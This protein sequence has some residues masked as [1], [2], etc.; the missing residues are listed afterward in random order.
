MQYEIKYIK[1]ETRIIDGKLVT[2]EKE[3]DPPKANTI[4]Q[5]GPMR[6]DRLTSNMQAE[7]KPIKT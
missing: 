2:I 3:L 1:T 6:N 7:L 4:Y 5:Y